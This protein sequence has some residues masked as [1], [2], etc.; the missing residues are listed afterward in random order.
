MGLVG[1]PGDRGW[2]EGVRV[3][4]PKWAGKPDGSQ[5]GLVRGAGG[6]LRHGPKEMGASRLLSQ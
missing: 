6:P 3:S 1:F 2:E 5:A 4:T